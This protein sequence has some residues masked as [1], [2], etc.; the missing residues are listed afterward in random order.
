MMMHEQV[1]GVG[2]LVTGLLIFITKILMVVLVLA[3]IAGI[4]SSLRKYFLKDG[5]ES[6]LIQAINQDP[7]LK[8]AAV[9]TGI[10]LGLLLILS[11]FGSLGMGGMGYH[12]NPMFTIAWLIA[13]IIKIL[14]I[15]LVIALAAALILYL[16][17]QYES[18]NLNFTNN[19]QNNTQQQIGEQQNNQENQQ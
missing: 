4:L 10:V 8:T 6:R 19:Q 7:I 9:I 14:M 12:F 15:V 18:G 13:T 3:I 11:L 17:K 1:Y 5:Q 16:K 2:G